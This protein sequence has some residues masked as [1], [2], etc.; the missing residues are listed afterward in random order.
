MTIISK[1]SNIGQAFPVGSIY[2]TTVGA[3]PSQLLGY[4]TWT[5]FSAGRYLVGIDEESSSEVEVG[6]SLGGGENRAVGSHTHIF[7]GAGIGSH[8]HGTNGSFGPNQFFGNVGETSSPFSVPQPGGANTD[9]AGLAFATLGSA[10][11]TISEACSFA[12]TNAPYITV[13]MWKRIA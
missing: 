7:T 5:I 8:I 4:G 12:G 6:L 11:G 9:V 2:I 1:T 3:N 13:F 10:R